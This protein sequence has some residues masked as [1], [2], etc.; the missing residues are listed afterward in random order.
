[1]PEPGSS[2]ILTGTDADSLPPRGLA[3]TY[4][5][6]FRLPSPMEVQAGR[7]GSA[8]L[9]AGWVI[10]VGSALG[11]GGLRA[12]LRRHLARE[13]RVHWHIDAL[14]T[15]IR[16]EF[17]LARADGERH[18]CAWTQHLAAH[19]AASIPVLGFGSSDCRRGCQS[20]LIAFP[21]EM[22]REALITWLLRS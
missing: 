21:A 1:M 14:S 7:L 16:P 15:R 20:H 4:A 11:P 22:D 2:L 6:F 9:P 13:K 5:L 19:P 12:R 8:P 3:G 18:E 10:Y 17:W